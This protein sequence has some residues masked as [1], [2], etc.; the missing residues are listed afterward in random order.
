[1]T[2]KYLHKKW[3]NG[4]TRGRTRGRSIHYNK[5]RGFTSRNYTRKAVELR[6]LDLDRD[7]EKEIM[8]DL[9]RHSA[10]TMIKNNIG[11]Y[12][13]RGK[14]GVILGEILDYDA[15]DP[16][17]FHFDIFDPELIRIL[18]KVSMSMRFSLYQRKNPE[19]I[20]ILGKIYNGLSESRDQYEDVNYKNVLK[21]FKILVKKIL[22]VEIGDHDTSPINVNNFLES[23]RL[24][25]LLIEPLME[26]S[27]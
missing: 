4:R 3:I 13:Y 27:D 18:A 26:T 10:A 9:K 16:D 22:D 15:F 7:I 1:M 25:D 17:S 2:N 23:D 5:G 24:Y 8:E 20:K 6:K 11:N 19:W 14:V 21:A 12:P